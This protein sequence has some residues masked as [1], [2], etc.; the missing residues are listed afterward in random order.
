MNATVSPLGETAGCAG[1]LSG[2]VLRC[3]A[4]PPSACRTS[5]KCEPTCRTNTRDLPFAVK[6]GCES[7][8]PSPVMRFGLPPAREAT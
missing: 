3:V 6:L 2:A 8:V 4:R 5:E 1:S 7:L